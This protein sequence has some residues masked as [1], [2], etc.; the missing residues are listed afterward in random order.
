M[1]EVKMTYLQR[2]HS[3]P[4]FRQKQLDRKKQLYHERNADKPKRQRK[5]I[6]VSNRQNRER[7]HSDLE[8]KEKQKSR[9][10]ARYY[11]MKS[12]VEAQA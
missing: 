4:E 1:T 3:D 7:Y 5:S 8:F 11:A 2:Y 9:S 12:T 10:L 6:E